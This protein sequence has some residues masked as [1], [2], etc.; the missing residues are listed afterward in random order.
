MTAPIIITEVAHA[1]K[2]IWGLF[3]FNKKL[4]CDRLTYTLEFTE[5]IRNFNKCESSQFI[6]Y[7][8]N[9]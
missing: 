6:E 8:T 2:C 4:K 3:T 7:F 9:N 5:K 1:F